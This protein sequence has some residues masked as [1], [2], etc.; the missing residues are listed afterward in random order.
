MLECGLARIQD[1]SF[2]LHKEYGMSGFLIVVIVISAIWVYWDATENKIGKVVGLKSA[3]NMSAG[4]WSIVTLL[5]WIIGFPAYIVK[6]SSLIETAKTSPVEVKGRIIK[7]SILAIVG[8]LWIASTFL[9]LNKETTLENTTITT[10]GEQT[11]PPQTN[12]VEPIQ[13]PNNQ[14]IEE[15]SK[16]RFVTESDWNECREKEAAT[17]SELEVGVAG[18]EAAMEKCG[19]K[20]ILLKAANQ[21]ALPKSDC[22]WLYQQPLEECLTRGCDDGANGLSN[23]SSGLEQTY[24]SKAFDF[25]K[26]D[27]LCRQACNTNEKIN[28]E[29]FGKEVC[30]GS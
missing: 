24:S 16:E 21:F 4:A 26:F 8:V 12:D 9:N 1:N 6:R 15:P 2:Y 13:H 14:S 25:K 30:G 27:A 22:D 20:P 11:T 18:V 28:R 23:A 17:V 29:S 3:F 19:S 7:L 10:T 5:L